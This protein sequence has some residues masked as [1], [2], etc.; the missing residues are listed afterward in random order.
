M[1]AGKAA[2]QLSGQQLFSNSDLQQDHYQINAAMCRF[3]V[4]EAGVECCWQPTQV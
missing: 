4:A 3:S 1:P 2:M